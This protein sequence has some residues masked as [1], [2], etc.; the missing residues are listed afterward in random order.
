MNDE[1][2]SLQK[3]LMNSTGVLC[4]GG[5]LGVIS[6][7]SL[8]DRIVKMF[9]RAICE[10]ESDP[11]TGAH[12]REPDFVL[13]LRKPIKPSEDEIIENPRSRSA[14]FRAIRKKL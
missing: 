11:V 14:K 4:P 2:N 8:E 3:F 10:P 1:L 12:V 7:H 6:F 5:R 13:F 9:F